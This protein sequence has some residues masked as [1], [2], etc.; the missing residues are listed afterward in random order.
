MSF[1]HRFGM[2]SHDSKNFKKGKKYLITQGKAITTNKHFIEVINYDKPD[3]DVIGYY[4]YFDVNDK[5]I[6]P[7]FKIIHDWAVNNLTPLI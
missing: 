2:A 6:H 4:D 7:D 3:L 1:G 5:T